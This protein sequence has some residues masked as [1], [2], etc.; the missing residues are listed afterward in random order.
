M[1]TLNFFLFIIF[2]LASIEL[3]A[4]VRF[5]ASGASTTST[6]QNYK[7]VFTLENGNGSGFKAPSFEGFRVLSGPNQSSSYQWVNGKTTQSLSIYYYLQALQ[8]G[9]LVIG[10][11]QI[12][13]DNQILKTESIKVSVKKG[14]SNSNNTANNNSNNNKSNNNSSNTNTNTNNENWKNQAK[15]QL[16]VKVYTDKAKPYVGEQIFLYA[17]L[18]QRVNTYGTQITKMPE[19]NG[20]WKQEIEVDQD[21]WQNENIDGVPYQTLVIGKFALFPQREGSF[22]IEPMEMQSIIMISE[23]T[24]RNFMGFQMQTMGYR[25]E[26]YN[27]KSTSLKIEV[28]ALPEEGK[29]LSFNGAVGK[30]EL[31]TSLDKEEV[32]LGEAINF[33]AIISGTGNIMAVS[34]PSIDFPK[35]L[36]IYDPQTSENISKRNNYINGS[37]T[38]EYLIVP[39]APGSFTLPSFEFSYFD[40]ESKSYKTLNSERYNIRVKGELAKT[41]KSKGHQDNLETLD[42]DIRYIYTKNDIRKNE[43]GFF[44]SGTYYALSVVPPFLYSLFFLFL[45]FK[46]NEN[47]DLVALK[48]KRASKEAQKRLKAAKKYLDLADKKAFYN[49]VFDVLNNYVSDKFNIQQAELNKELIIEKFAEK[50]VSE[51]LA[52]QFEQLIQNAEM[53]LYSPTSSLKMQEDYE[54]TQSCIIAIENELNV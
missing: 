2:S 46:E 41:N 25:Q 51:S 32:D 26:E 27:F 6:D 9:D 40:L 16:F 18:Y 13:V 42:E 35:N 21:A 37:K 22:T 33:K 23:P 43:Q 48:N 28:Q 4:Q 29:P 54:L 38:Y 45:K 19:F 12:S 49:E 15:D 39:E 50:Q 36:E 10:P 3:N 52:L 24:V 34:E 53:A 17:K 47:A 31:K 1:K 20:F 44:G 7:V 8:E 5:Y 30:F 11:A 14:S